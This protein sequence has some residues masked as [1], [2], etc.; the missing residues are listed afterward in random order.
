MTTRTRYER[1][2]LLWSVLAARCFAATDAA[3]E[4]PA[5]WIRQ[6]A[7]ALQ[8]VE[9]SRDRNDL[10]ALQTIVGSA[11]VIGF[12][13]GAHG[14]HEFLSLRNR[15]FQYLVEK[16]G[17]TAYTAETGFMEAVPVDDYVQGRGELTPELVRRVFSWSQVPMEENRR[18]I[19]WIRTYNARATTKRA[20][21]FY[22]IDLSGCFAGRYPYA[23]R[24][25]DAALEYVESLDADEA[26]PLAQRLEPLLGR[27]NSSDYD[28]LSALE[29][30]SLT[31]A[32]ADLL[33]LFDRRRVE[34]AARTSILA[35][36]R[37]YQYA[38]MARHLDANFRASGWGSG[39]GKIGDM[40]QRDAAQ[41]DNL[42]WVLEREGPQGRIFVFEQAGHLDGRMMDFSRYKDI[43]FPPTHSKLTTLGGR[44]RQA[45]GGDWIT[46]G[47]YWTDSDVP[48]LQKQAAKINGE[49]GALSGIL[50]QA[51]LPL[52]LLDTRGMPE[53]GAFAAYRESAGA[54]GALIFVRAVTAAH[55]MEP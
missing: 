50:S 20:V 17:V 12:A 15:I 22:G 38:V 4:P 31:V 32:I 39:A 3:P 10:R 7:L 27:F 11:R 6:H 14:T 44:V 37:A 35:S 34:W 54:F 43:K 42:R 36:E 5:R 45:L 33:G 40:N 24:V 1:S 49:G 2:L 23:R 28:Q 48:A 51:G 8:T 53:E 46:I 13:E 19:E 52:F 16:K 26:Q 25:V 18:L 41:A 30:D 9:P 55:P 47:T 29:R 21:R